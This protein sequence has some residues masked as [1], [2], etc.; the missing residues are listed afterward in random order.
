MLALIVREKERCG[1]EERHTG[2]FAARAELRI[3]I[4]GG[5]RGEESTVSLPRRT[6]VLDAR[7]GVVEGILPC[8]GIV[9]GPFHAMRQT[10]SILAECH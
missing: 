6:D 9:A 1:V 8:S 4:V 3:Y 5:G 10:I 7:G 2:R